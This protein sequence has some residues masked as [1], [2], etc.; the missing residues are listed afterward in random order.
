T[1][2]EEIFM[3]APRHVL[4]GLLLVAASFLSGAARADRWQ[5]G[6]PRAMPSLAPPPEPPPPCEEHCWLLSQFTLRG[7]VRGAVSFELRG[8]VRAR[9]EQRIPLFGPPGQVRLEGVTIDGGPAQIGFEGDEY[10]LLTKRRS[11]TLRG[12]LH[13]GTDHL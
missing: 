13:L 2:R 1:A 11:F 5:T 10:F 12:T 7:D 9:E 8:S 4:L 3:L 6:E